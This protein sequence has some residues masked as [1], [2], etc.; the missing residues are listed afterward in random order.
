M[1]C[2]TCGEPM[3]RADCCISLSDSLDTHPRDGR[4]RSSLGPAAL[5]RCDACGAEFLWARGRALCVLFEGV[6][7][8]DAWARAA[9]RELDVLAR[10]SLAG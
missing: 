8:L 5:Y 2:A 6:V 1:T 3:Q 10:R 7:P 9:R 4:R